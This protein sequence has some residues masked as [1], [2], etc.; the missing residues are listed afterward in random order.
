MENALL[1]PK[2]ILIIQFRYLGD[3]V[4]LTPAITSI[5][6]RF[7]N[8]EIHILVADEIKPV[9]EHSPIIKK[10]WSIPRKRGKIEISLTEIK[11]SIPVIYNLRKLKFDFS[12][13]FYGNDRGA[14][15]SL[16]IN[17]EKRFAATNKNSIIKK[18]AYSNSISDRQLPNN[19][20]QSN[21]EL[22]Y[23]FFQIPKIENPELKI[24]INPNIKDWG[25][26]YLGEHLIICHLGT[27]KEI[28]EWPLNHW[29]K[30]YNLASE[31][32]YLLAF[33]S[34]PNQREQQLLK[35]LKNEI[36]QIF[37]I[38]STNLEKFLSI[39]N[40]AEVFISGDTGPLHFAAALGKKIIGLYA[41]NDSI[42]KAVPIY[43]KNE[44]I[45][46][47]KCKCIL[48][49]SALCNMDSDRCMGS[50]K[51]EDVLSLLKSIHPIENNIEHLQ[52][53]FNL[54]S[55]LLV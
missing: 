40:A 45:I 54:N 12:I 6:E 23:N 32:G 2:K 46:G 48:K 52:K 19:Y 44:C 38:T 9:F 16:I 8:A 17:A 18:I 21:L 11:K 13:D 37:D 39:I 28:K 10:V 49:S 25:K 41:E 55:E 51:P 26:N 35:H 14:F 53:S 29:V 7:P 4:F 3:A 1:N 15:F 24:G 30:F 27:S 20:V 47:T 31:A 43:K 36:P 42:I 22:I 5:H 33:S 34:G 50:I